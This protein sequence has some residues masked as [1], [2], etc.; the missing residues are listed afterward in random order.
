VANAF[1][2][3]ATLQVYDTVGSL[4]YSSY[5]SLNS[6]TYAGIG[7]ALQGNIFTLVGDTQQPASGGGFSPPASFAAVGDVSIGAPVAQAD[8]SITK[9]DAPDPVDGGDALTYTLTV[10]NAGPDPAS[11][12]VV[13]DTLPPGTTVVTIGSTQG[14][15]SSPSEMPMTCTL[16]GLAAGASATV[17]IVVTSPVSGTLTNTG[18]VTSDTPD[19]DAGNNSA[20][21]TTTVDPR[22]ADVSITKAAAPDP[23]DVGDNLTYTLMV[24]NRGPSTAANVVVTESV[25][26]G[27]VVNSI[28]TTQG[29][30]DTTVE[31]SFD[32][33]LGDLAANATATI[34]VVV[35]P[36]L[37]GPLT[38]VASVD[39]AT[40]DPDTTN[41]SATVVTTV[42]RR[43]EANLSVTKT[44]T[45]DPAIQGD[46]VTYTVTIV[47][48]GPDTAANVVVT[49]NT[50]GIPFVFRSVQASQG[51][52]AGGVCQLGAMAAGASATVTVLVAPLEAG[53]LVN[54][55][56]VASDTFDPDAANNTA[57][58]NT[59]VRARQAD[60]S[61]TKIDDPDPVFAG[62]ELTY[63][64]TIANAGPDT[65]LNVVVTESIPPESVVVVSATT[66][67]G[68]CGLPQANLICSLGDLAAGATATV[69]VVVIPGQPGGISNTATVASSTPDDNSTNNTARAT[70]MVRAAADLSIEK[71]GTPDPVTT[72]QNL[73]Y[74]LIVT[75]RGP[76]TA[77]NVVVTES[78][79]VGAV[80]VSLETTHGRC[81]TTVELEFD[82]RLGDLAPGTTATITFVV[83]P[84]LPGPLPNIATV[85]S[86]TPD[87]DTTNNSATAVTSV[88]PRFEYCLQD[89]N[90]PRVTLQLDS[91]TG[92][93]RFAR[94]NGTVVT[95][96]GRVARSGRI[97]TLTHAAPG[98][99]VLAVIDTTRERATASLFTFPTGG[100]TLLR[101][102]DTTNNVCQSPPEPSQSGGRVTA[103][104]PSGRVVSAAMG[105]MTVA[106]DQ[107]MNASSFTA[108][109]V[110]FAGPSG[111]I[112]I[113]AVS[114]SGVTSFEI[115]F[116]PQRDAGTYTLTVGPGIQTATGIPMDQ[117]GNGLPGEVPDDRFT[118]TVVIPSADL[119]GDGDVDLGDLSIVQ[120]AFGTRR[121]DAGYNPQA[122]FDD[123]GDI[124]LRDSYFL[125][126]RLRP[127][128][129]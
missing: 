90:D 37:D 125:L 42:L 30:C 86:D 119:D 84:T 89:D 24:T 10:T 76:L 127:G 99:W 106:F 35:T 40:S 52:C 83:T 47:N 66:S 43:Q 59:T 103:S 14:S 124:D 17:T 123:D 3:S 75:N 29:V 8:L 116:D 51:T 64:L 100:L 23:V 61:I 22:E 38:N 128:S 97:I 104:D 101:D 122:D 118:A 112:P 46:E 39:S 53:T 115:R 109:D 44:D 87:P 58:E 13:T 68:T 107:P 117:N 50:V 20:T 21:A 65:A 2:S 36:D 120:R 55:A 102:T 7:G 108:D 77:A 60:L 96:T 41:N 121:G 67:Q 71:V 25:P 74:R 126:T 129:V 15:C 49:D 94:A 72:G 105:A 78:V 32:C 45:P 28:A 6:G 31:F 26:V 16:G 80:V 69:T 114:P 1:A 63:T 4:E 11:N 88:Q 95:G 111:A 34:T 92:E 98:R 110:S 82:C 91:Q 27:A 62:S 12:V 73:T 81:D 5:F 93:Y 18:N 85:R 79:P 113:V 33:R 57:T 9:T 48:N 54:T 56:T 19:P 70:T